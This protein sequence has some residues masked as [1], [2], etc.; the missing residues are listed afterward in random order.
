M[1]GDKS[2]VKTRR[3]RRS[4]HAF[5]QRQRSASYASSACSVTVRS[6]GILEQHV[7]ID[8]GGVNLDKR[9]VNSSALDCKRGPGD[10]LV[11]RAGLLP[12]FCICSPWRK[13]SRNRD[14]LPANE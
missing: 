2:T 10:L 1:T 4:L 9:H 8:S 11:R 6:S 5:C 7:R 13:M 14:I 3:C 12:V